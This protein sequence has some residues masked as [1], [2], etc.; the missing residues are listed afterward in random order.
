MRSN[1]IYFEEV[2]RTNEMRNQIEESLKCNVR[3]INL[4]YLRTSS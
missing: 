4:F 1:C 2:L 3:N